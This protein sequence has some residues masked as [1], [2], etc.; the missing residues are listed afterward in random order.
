[1]ATSWERGDLAGYLEPYAE[2]V[3]VVRPDR[4]TRGREAL[5]AWARREREWKMGAAP[6]VRLQ[7]T[8]MAPQVGDTIVQTREYRLEK[9]G[10]EMK[11][12]VVSHWQSRNGLWQIVREEVGRDT[13]A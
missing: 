6:A 4:T 12:I 5:I 11:R 2:D 7:S 1:M 3:V 10:R 9:D 8:S 13:A